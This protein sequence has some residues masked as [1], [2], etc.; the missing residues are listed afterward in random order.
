MSLMAVLKFVSSKHG[1][2]CVA[3]LGIQWMLKW[4]ADSLDTLNLVRLCVYVQPQ[5]IKGRLLSLKSVDLM[6]F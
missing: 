1:N 5:L 3:I 2:Q 4:S 6:V